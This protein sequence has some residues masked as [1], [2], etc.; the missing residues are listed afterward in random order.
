ML[1]AKHGCEIGMAAL[2][3]EDEFDRDVKLFEAS[4]AMAKFGAT[5]FDARRVY[6]WRMSFGVWALLA[7]AAYRGF[8]VFPV[9]AVVVALVG[10]GWWLQNLWLRNSSDQELIWNF[11]NEAQGLLGKHGIK[12]VSPKSDLRSGRGQVPTGW[13]ARCGF[14]TDWSM[15]FQFFVTA[16]LLAFICATADNVISF[17]VVMRPGAR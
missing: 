3:P 13:R 2:V 17:H 14:L 1:S 15:V 16:G 9:A 6:E 4:M 10:H 7:A 11:A 8:T 12:I 5:R